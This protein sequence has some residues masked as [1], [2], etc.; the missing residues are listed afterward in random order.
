MQKRPAALALV[1]RRGPMRVRSARPA[2]RS[3]SVPGSAQ[4]LVE[5][6]DGNNRGNAAVTFR[7]GLVD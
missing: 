5:K 1:T 2:G 3:C 4:N 6:Q 7:A